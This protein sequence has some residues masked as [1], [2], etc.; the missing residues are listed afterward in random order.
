MLT[1]KI[2]KILGVYLA[3]LVSLS[4]AYPNMNP[5]KVLGLS[6]NADEK[7]IRLAYRKLA[8]EWFVFFLKISITFH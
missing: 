1:T 6:R 5:Y 2:S 7:D 3:T 8:K 4:L